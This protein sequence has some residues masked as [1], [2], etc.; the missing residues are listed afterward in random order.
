M[1]TIILY[2]NNGEIVF[3]MVGASVE[4]TYK[5]LVSDIE[6]NKNIVGVDPVTNSVITEDKNTRVADIKEYLD[7]TDDTTIS[8]VED[9]IL[10][11]ESN[12]I[13]DENGGM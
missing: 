3:S 4:D 7:N 13:L 11:T 10:E 2:K 6:E 9:T 1:K 5:C 12:K 8:K